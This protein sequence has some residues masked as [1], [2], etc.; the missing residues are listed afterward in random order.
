M[1]ERGEL[2]RYKHVSIRNNAESVAL[3]NAEGFE[4][5]QCRSLFNELLRR[6][7]AFMNWKLPN[8]CGLFV[9]WQQLFD[10]YGAILTYSIQYIPIFILHSYDDKKPDELGKIISNNAFFYIMLVNSFTRLIDVALNFGEMAGILQRVAEIEKAAESNANSSVEREEG[11]DEVSTETQTVCVAEGSSVLN[12]DE[13]DILMEMN[14]VTYGVA[15]DLDCVLIRG[16]G[17]LDW[18]LIRGE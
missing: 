5:E 12:L 1:G 14:G 16:V 6:Q 9:F 18:V 3:Y 15:S 4:A 2:L 8:L 10:Y 7:M 13:C 17:D 11:G